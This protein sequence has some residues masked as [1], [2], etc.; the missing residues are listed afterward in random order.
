MENK[1]RSRWEEARIYEA[2]PQYD[3]S[4]N[5]LPKFM[6]TFPYPYMNG[7]MHIGHAFSLVRVETLARYK[8]MT[9]HNVLFPFAF[10]CTGS[11]IVNAAERIKEGEE[12]QIKILRDMGIPEDD[13][14]KFADP[15]HWTRHFPK[16]NKQDLKTFGL[17]IDWRRSFITTEIN[18][19]YDAFIRWQFRKLKAGN[20]VRLGDHPVIWCPKC[21]SPTGDHGRSEGEGETPS[22]MTLLKFQIRNSDTF[23][24]AATLRPE[25]VY[26]QT[27]LWVDPD[28]DYPILDVDGEKWIVS[29][30]CAEK[31]K[32]QGHAIKNIETMP[33]ADLVGK[34]VI[35]PGIDRE[36]PILPSQF[37]DPAIGTGIVTSVPSDAPDDWVA[38][39]DLQRNPEECQRWGLDPEF[40]QAIK[41]VAIIHSEGWGDLPAVEIV[42]K[43]GIDNQMERDKLLEAKHVIYRSGFYTGKM[44][45]NTGKYAGMPVEYAKEEVK[46]DLIEA[47][48]ASMMWEPSGKVVCRCLTPC[49]VKLV[50]NQWFLA[51][52]DEEWKKKVKLSLSRMKLYPAAV[53]KQFEN[54]IDW[55]R[56]WA[57]TR[58]MGMGTKLPW[59]EQWMIESLSDSTIYMS[60]YTMAKAFHNDKDIPADALDDDFFD[61]VLLGEG[62]VKTLSKRSGIPEDRIQEMRREFLYWYPMDFRGSGKDLIQNHLAFCIYN[63]TA[64]FPEEHW[65]G[66]FGLNGW[67]RVEGNK[68][69]KSLG[70]FFTIRQIL[71]KYPADVVRITLLS[72]GEGLDDPN[73]ESEFADSVQKRLV[74]FRELARNPPENMTSD[75][76]PIDRW[77]SST[78][79][80]TIQE[81]RQAMEL[82]NFRTAVKAGFFD[83]QQNYRWYMR[84]NLGVPNRD[85]FNR[86]LKVQTLLIAPVTP[87]ICEDIWEGLGKEGFVVAAPYPEAKR[88]NR[89]SDAEAEEDYLRSVMDDIS[90]ILKVVGKTPKKAIIY[91]TPDWKRK[92]M[93]KGLKMAAD[94]QVDMGGLIKSCMADPDV[95]R[96][97]KAVPPFAKEVAELMRKSGEKE[98]ERFATALPET[99]I[100]QNNLK[101][102]ETEYGFPMEVYSA[103]DR[104]FADPANKS[105]AARPHRPAIYLDV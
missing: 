100:I 3:E 58:E 55:L 97:A 73:W 102:L 52:G 28:Y 47:K 31:L 77:F 32:D 89:T 20:Y 75:E 16:I 63:H 91:T 8:R 62:N 37:T 76:R 13:I 15:V 99:D 105:R 56:D 46:K 88:T 85:V 79:D 48:K 25:T 78:M 80:R 57:C 33:G 29:K 103:D 104:G 7:Y 68:M 21:R 86:F 4:G 69:S 50:S 17:A 38:L 93:D 30:E 42:E 66:G 44:L 84:R 98:R 34:L 41:P 40:V 87:H 19:H 54:V 1:W 64:I 70:N 12:T 36:I 83:L 67:I 53:R 82:T 71:E 24:M 9:G 45:P 60:Y 39:R 65:P 23:L 18:P 10:H 61:Y 43:M 11:P 90:Q 81:C 5:P 101:F 96:N 49:T 51:Y 27:N 22:E 74:T 2:D 35:A 6:L 92:V 72:G 59:D 94:G 14:P 26:G 95:K